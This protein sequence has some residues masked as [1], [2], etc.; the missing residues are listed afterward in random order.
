MSNHFKLKT[1]SLS[2]VLLLLVVTSFKSPDKV[3][4]IEPNEICNPPEGFF[5]KIRTAFE[6]IDIRRTVVNMINSSIMDPA[7]T[8]ISGGSPGDMFGCLSYIR[9]NINDPRIVDKLSWIPP[10]CHTYDPAFCEG[11]DVTYQEADTQLPAGEWIKAMRD[12]RSAGSLIGMG[13]F[14]EKAANEPPPANLAY[15]ANRQVEKLPV[16][17][18]A[19]AAGG[20]TAYSG[21]M[22]NAV[23]E[24]W[25]MFRNA[26]YAI[27]A[28]VMIV[29]GMMIM[30]RK[31]LNP[32]AVVTVQYAIP[33]IAI[34][35]V[36][37]TF[38]YPI[39]ATLA[40]IAFALSNS[41]EGIVYSLLA[42]ET[43]DIGTAGFSIL[44]GGF[45]LNTLSTGGFNI[46]VIFVVI[47]ICIILWIL[48][49]FKFVMLYFKMLINI[50]GAPLIF[51][52]GAVPGKEDQTINWFKKMIS[53]LLGMASIYLVF[54]LTRL[55]AIN[56]LLL[57][58]VDA[59]YFVVAAFMGHFL[60]AFI[61]M[62]GY[63]LARKMPSKV[64]EAIMGPKKPGGKR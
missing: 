59:D 4:A 15:Y 63:N 6:D 10:D 43:F 62:Y 26:A 9:A 61:V 31:K 2:L 5:E 54:I 27:M 45:M 32:Q 42:P 16:V 48:A 53:C 52:Y 58:T 22:L 11:L 41:V 24:F 30:T 1:F 51:A 8:A 46:V 34:A 56:V 17:G 64:D 13:N 49:M 50:I 28:V 44:I 3:C 23:Y 60:V 39:G 29:V 25:E 40:S 18:T 14:L 12:T 36:L 19:M 33:R 20:V 38:S 21:P 35:L 55:I 37:I 7:S 57:S 47:L